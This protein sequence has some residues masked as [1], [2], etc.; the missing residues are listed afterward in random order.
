ML[1]RQLAVLVLVLVLVAA[2]WRDRRMRL[3]VTTVATSTRGGLH[4]RHLG[5]ADHWRR[6]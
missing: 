6:D 5:E 4:P 3:A 1:R 2:L